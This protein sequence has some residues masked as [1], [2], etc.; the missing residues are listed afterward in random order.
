MIIRD[1]GPLRT[2]FLNSYNRSCDVN[3]SAVAKSRAHL[4]G[5]KSRPV[6]R[7]VCKISALY[8]M[9][10]ARVAIK[11]PDDVVRWLFGMSR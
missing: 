1:W 9:H 5:L 6:K 10:A 3:Q 11:T 7:Q 8:I 2:R 4:R